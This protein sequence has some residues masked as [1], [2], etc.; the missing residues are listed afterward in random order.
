[1]A[2][3]EPVETLDDEQQNLLRRTLA[4]GGRPLNVFTTLVRWPELMKRVNALGGYFQRSS[5][6]DARLREVVVLRAAER[7]GSAY[8]LAH[9]RG[10]ATQQGLAADAIAAAEAG[11]LTYPWSRTERAALSL[12]DELLATDRVG[13]LTWQESVAVLGERRA[14]ECLFLAGFY[15]MLGG[16]LNAVEVDVDVRVDRPLVGG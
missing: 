2:R 1:M 16:F 9:H 6:V 10:L 13:A 8:E 5:E 4:P 11:D 3:I 7:T 12:A 15:R 14:V